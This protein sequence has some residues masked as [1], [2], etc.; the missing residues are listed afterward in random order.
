MTNREGE[1]RRPTIT[2]LAGVNGAGKSSI[3]GAALRALG[4]DYFNPDEMTRRI[5]RHDP[6]M[7]PGE[8]NRLAWH[9]GKRLLERAIAERKD[10]VFETTLGGDTLTSLLERALDEGMDVR[11]WFVGLE[12][13]ELHIARVAARV[14]RGGH[15]VPE[16]TIRARYVTSRMH[17]IRLLPRLAMLKVYDNSAD[18]D[19]SLGQAPAPRLVLHMERGRIQGPPNLALTPRWAKPIV[20]AA[21]RETPPLD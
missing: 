5:L 15:D 20:A 1:A 10:D 16:E 21:L 7:P 11:L 9:H 19:P 3:A 2:V 13:P 6:V 8:A 12:G 4:G 18:G 14:A 17:L